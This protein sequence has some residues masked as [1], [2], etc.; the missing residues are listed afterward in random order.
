MKIKNKLIRVRVTENEHEKVFK[1][2]KKAGFKR[3]SH[4]F[5]HFINQLEKGNKNEPIN[6][7]SSLTCYRKT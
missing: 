6:R 4:M 1:L 3:L 7:N 5:W 2:V